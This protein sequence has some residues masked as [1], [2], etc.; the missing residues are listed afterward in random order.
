MVGVSMYTRITKV[1]MYSRITGV[2]MNPRTFC[3]NKNIQGLLKYGWILKKQEQGWIPVL[4]GR[5][6]ELPW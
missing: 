2:R 6:L 3:R 4:P 5:I 1:S